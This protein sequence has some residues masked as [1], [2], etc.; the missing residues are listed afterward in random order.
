MSRHKPPWIR[1][2]CQFRNRRSIF[3]RKNPRCRRPID[4][5]LTIPLWFRA[6]GAQLGALLLAYGI[7]GVTG[8][9]GS[10]ESPWP[11]LA[12]QGVLAA[13][14][15]FPLGLPCWWLPIEAA[16]LPTVVFV[17]SL[18]IPPPV[19]LGSFLILWLIYRSNTRERV[20]LYLSNKAAWRALG[21]LLSERVNPRFLDLGSGLGGMLHYLARCQPKGEFQ[22]VESAPLPYL[23]SRLRLLGTPQC[24]GPSGRSVAGESGPIR[25]HLRLSITRAH[26]GAMGQG[27]RRDAGGLHP[28]QQ[29]LRNPWSRPVP[30]MATG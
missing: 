13:A 3:R 1:V 17:L 26:A 25:C 7:F 9:L 20:P 24:A 15:S 14:L 22:G 8:L 21:V 2:P 11:F 18:Q 30:G 29:Y 4:G 10:L 6:L 16:F 12:L 28:G 27:P 5:V 23:I 19:F